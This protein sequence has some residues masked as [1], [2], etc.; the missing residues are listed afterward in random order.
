[1]VTTGTITKQLRVTRVDSSRIDPRAG[2]GRVGLRTSLSFLQFFLEY[3]ILRES[4]PL[5]PPMQSTLCQNG[6]DKQAGASLFVAA[7]RVQ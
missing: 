5:L 1:M 3:M 2:L 4:E 7:A 6:Y